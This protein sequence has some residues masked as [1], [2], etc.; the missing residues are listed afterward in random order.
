VT[1]R[2]ATAADAARL[3]DIHLTSRAAAMPWLATPHDARETAAWMAG[4]V[5]VEDTVLVDEE[6]GEVQGFA[7][8]HD[9]WLEHLYVDPARQGRGV[10]RRLLAAAQALRPGG[11][12]LFVFTRNARARRFYERAGFVL[13]EQGDGSGNEEREPDC[14]YRWR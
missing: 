1:L 4:V 9:D 10:G 8:L 7:A 2:P 14:L 6:D 3:T 5:L 11:L 13:V 12:R